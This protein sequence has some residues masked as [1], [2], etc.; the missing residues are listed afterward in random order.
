MVA[1]GGSE[2]KEETFSFF[3]RWEKY[4]IFIRGWK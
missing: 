3:L 1:G 4:R 2:R